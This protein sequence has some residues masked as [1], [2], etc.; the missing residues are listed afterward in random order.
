VKE[1]LLWQ[2]HI[3]SLFD[4]TIFT[5]PWDY[6]PLTKPAATL[7]MTEIDDINLMPI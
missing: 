6:A 4:N 5:T 2:L 1:M 3:I 7:F